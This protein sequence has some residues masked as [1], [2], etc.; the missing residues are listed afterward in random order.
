MWYHSKM[1]VSNSAKLKQLIVSG[2]GYVALLALATTLL[3]L[4]LTTYPQPWFDEGYFL[5]VAKMLAQYGLYALPDSDGPWVMD[6]SIT[7]G[8]VLI[9]PIALVFQH[10]GVGVLQGRLVAVA[11]GLLTFA[12][13]ALLARRLVGG[14]AIGALLL[15]LAGTPEPF[16]SFVM[17]ARQA[18]GEVTA[19]GLCIYGIWLWLRAFDLGRPSWWRLACAG[20]ALGLAIVA[21]PQM[22]IGVPAALALACLAD[23]CYYRQATWRA[24][25]IPAVVTVGCVT[26]WYI[27][28][29]AIVGLDAFRAKS[30]ILRAGLI[31]NIVSFDPT[32][33]KNA[34]GALWRSGFFV[35]GLPGLLYGCRLARSRTRTGLAHAWVLALVLVWLGWFV[36]LSI[37]WARYSFLIIA[38]APIW[39]ARLACDILRRLAGAQRIAAA[40]GLAALLLANSRPILVGV[41]GAQDRSAAEFSNYLRAKVPPDAIV[42]NW[43]WNLDATAPQRFHHPPPL[44]MYEVIDVIQRGGR[45]RSDIYAPD[46]AR[47]DYVVDG[48]FSSWT[49]IYHRYITAHGRL[50]VKVGPYALYRVIR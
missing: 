42:E 30:A 46:V 13:Y 17:M 19:L 32:H 22:I 6:Q 40:I 5:S 45:P 28:Q 37:G 20:A 44:V 25:I 2:W 29:I 10:L 38:L 11:L 4:N 39:S 18:I 3:L 48:P 9:V 41:F 31:N 14:A 12:A 23:R 27:A 50:V 8:P 16:T 33:L 34:V 43:E 47:P 24:F 49:G 21:K 35:W 15:L 1:I 7:S 36:L 26:A